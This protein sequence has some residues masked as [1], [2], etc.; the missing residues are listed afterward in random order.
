[1][2]TQ[3]VTYSTK[4]PSNYGAEEA[5]KSI[6]NAINSIAKIK[7]EQINFQKEIMLDQYKREKDLELYKKKREID[8]SI[9][10]E[11]IPGLFNTVPENIMQQSTQS[12]GTNQ[13]NNQ[14]LMLDGVSMPH[15]KD[16]YRAEGKLT[17]QLQTY[18]GLYKQA[19]DGTLTEKGKNLMFQ[20]VGLKQDLKFEA[21]QEE[22]QRQRDTYSEMVRNS[23]R[24]TL[25]T[26]TEI[27][28][29]INN[30]G[31]IGGLPSI[32][33]TERSDWEANVNKLLS[34]KVIDIMTKM[35]EASKTGATGF[36]QLS[37]KELK[38][39]QDSSTALKRTLRPEDAQKYLNQMKASLYKVI[40]TSDEYQGIA[41]QNESDVSSF[42]R[43]ALGQ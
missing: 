37:N 3:P 20:L 8:N 21:E 24:D 39:L 19:S 1:M 36:G 42:I 30:F 34:Q 14:P 5:S 10:S 6:I 35:K 17:P 33:G 38:V 23:A 25:D 9:E 16:L 26:I 2:T 32:P 4:I 15:P 27:E 12:Q 43:K 29:G 40:G 18:A 11:G 7:Q 31:L 13:V 28:K 22:K 41:N